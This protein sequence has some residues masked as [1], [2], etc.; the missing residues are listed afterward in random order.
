MLNDRYADQILLK[1][2]LE[3]DR[4]ALAQW[5]VDSYRT[6]VIRAVKA[7]IARRLPGR[8][9]Q[10]FITSLVVHCTWMIYNKH[11]SLP[12]RFFSLKTQVRKFAIAYINDYLKRYLRANVVP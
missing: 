12:S 4:A 7:A 8:L 11:G 3:G 6:E 2:C 1:R 5:L 10:E 9:S